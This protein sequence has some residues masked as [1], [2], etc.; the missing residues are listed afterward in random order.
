[1]K[2]RLRSRLFNVSFEIPN[3]VYAIAGATAVAFLAVQSFAPSAPQKVH[4]EIGH[5]V[6]L[7]TEAA[8]RA[9]EKSVEAN[10]QPRVEKISPDG[11]VFRNTPLIDPPIPIGATASEEKDLRIAKNE[12]TSKKDKT[13]VA[14]PT[15]STNGYYYE[16]I[17]AQGDGDGEDFELVKRACEQP[18]H[19]PL[20][21]Y[22]P[23]SD[24][25]K[26]P[27]RGS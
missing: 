16:K 17:L 10:R 9:S 22:Y 20:A 26:F 11:W 23:Q 7:V 1:M 12:T 6:T 14:K 21:C 2:S 15:Q 18:F 25:W 27:V 3:A 5:G 24:R 8:G 13:A 19:M 4:V